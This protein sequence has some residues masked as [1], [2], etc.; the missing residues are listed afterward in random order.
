MPT[1]APRPTKATTIPRQ[2]YQ[3]TL[4]ID[5]QSLGEVEVGLGLI[6]L[7]LRD[8]R[9]HETYKMRERKECGPQ[10]GPL[11]GA[12]RP[13]LWGGTTR[14]FWGGSTRYVGGSTRGGSTGTTRRSSAHCRI[15]VP[16]VQTQ[17]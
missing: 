4:M 9:F 1:V 17:C 14:N 7:T 5:S 12:E 2:T 3:T 15:S 16:Y 10:C 13:T 6:R 8:G 11:G